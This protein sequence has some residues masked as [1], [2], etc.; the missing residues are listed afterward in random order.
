MIQ[1]R[2]DGLGGAGPV[3]TADRVRVCD[4][5]VRIGGP[6]REGAPTEPTLSL[7]TEDGVVLAIDVTCVCGERFRI[8]CE[9]N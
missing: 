7:V 1:E 4:G 8:R 6:R 3:V 2:P 5:V 9:Y